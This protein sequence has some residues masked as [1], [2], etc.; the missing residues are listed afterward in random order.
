MNQGSWIFARVKHG[1]GYL[2]RQPR[3]QTL[4]EGDV[5][6]ARQSAPAT[7]RA[8]QL[9]P[10]A[11]AY[12]RVEPGMLSGVLSPLERQSLNAR[13]RQPPTRSGILSPSHPVARRFA[14][15]CGRRNSSSGLV[16]RVQLLELATAVLVNELPAPPPPQPGQSATERFAD[17]MRRL[18]GSPSSWSTAPRNLPRC[19]V[20]ARAIST[21]CSRPSSDGR[22]SRSRSI[23]D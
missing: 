9:G 8:S 11:L 3:P 21:G 12:F 13:H 16:Q 22:W 14:E 17:L 5:I 1:D 20:A 18:P 6:V 19:A 7:V 2:L 10:L 15:I 23:C 4:A